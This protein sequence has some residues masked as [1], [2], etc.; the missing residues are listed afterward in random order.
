VPRR[1]TAAHA[2]RVANADAGT[3]VPHDLLKRAREESRAGLRRD[4]SMK[5]L[6]LHRDC[7]Q[8]AT[9]QDRYRTSLLS[10]W[11]EQHHHR[12]RQRARW[13]ARQAWL[14]LHVR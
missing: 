10:S 5:T 14:A 11:G 13:I 7:Q 12:R 8:C 3:A 9:W 1:R 2:V 4:P 6:A